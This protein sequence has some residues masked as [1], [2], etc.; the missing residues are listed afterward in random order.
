MNPMSEH[1]V[2]HVPQWDDC[3]TWDEGNFS[4]DKSLLQD[5]T[6]PALVLDLYEMVVRG[7]GSNEEA[8]Q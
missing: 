7:A 1:E 6:I 4:D 3:W 8:K 5:V 2:C